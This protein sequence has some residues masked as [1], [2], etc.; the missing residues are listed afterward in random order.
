M[1]W[2]FS[3]LWI[4]VCL[5]SMSQKPLW[6]LQNDRSIDLWNAVYTI[7][8]HYILLY[9]IIPGIYSIYSSVKKTFLLQSNCFQLIEL[10]DSDPISGWN[11]WVVKM[12]QLFF[13]FKMGHFDAGDHSGIL[14]PY[15]N[16]KMGH[17]PL[18]KKNGPFSDYAMDY[19][20]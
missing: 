7:V 14:N 5:F 16:A 18:K 3:L 9:L 11:E 20:S 1:N 8:F 15:R 19:R 10:H 17:P 12:G 6:L 13:A 2:S 4:S